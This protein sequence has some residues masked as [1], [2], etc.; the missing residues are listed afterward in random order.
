VLAKV[1]NKGGHTPQV[2][3]E[4]NP[5][6]QPL[7]FTCPVN[8]NSS[9]QFSE[10]I[11]LL[12]NNGNHTSST[13]LTADGATSNP[14]LDLTNRALSAA[15]DNHLL[16]LVCT[17]FSSM[18]PFNKRIQQHIVRLHTSLTRKPASKPVKNH[19]MVLICT[20]ECK[21]CNPLYNAYMDATKA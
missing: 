11:P 8:I 10:T 21:P 15:I 6:L 14:T 18:F 17:T 16:F 20:H 9:C 12:A 4:S 7:L 2:K 3:A 13:N 1:G 5:N 19:A